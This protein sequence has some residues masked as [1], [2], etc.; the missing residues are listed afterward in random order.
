M[1]KQ[2]IY[3]VIYLMCLVC[4]GYLCGETVSLSAHTS[5]L[6]EA[7]V[8]YEERLEAER[9]QHKLIIEMKE[10]NWLVEKASCEA[11]GVIYTVEEI[12]E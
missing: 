2:E 11:K 9:L 6:L 1:S 7:Q 5:N 3:V 10:L 12:N 8:N 4:A